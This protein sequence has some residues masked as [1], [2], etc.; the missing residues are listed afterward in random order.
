MGKRR[1]AY[2]SAKLRMAADAVSDVAN[3]LRRYGQP[4]AANKLMALIFKARAVSRHL[5]TGEPLPD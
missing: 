1:D 3:E 5:D 2:L 4:D